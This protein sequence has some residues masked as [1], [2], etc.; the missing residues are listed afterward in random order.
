[1]SRTGRILLAVAAAWALSAAARASA[2]P[3]LRPAFSKRPTYGES[4]TF[5]ADLE[6]GGYVQ[7]SLGITNLLPGST[8]GVC[9]ALVV[10]PAGAI[11][12]ESDRFGRDRVSWSLDQE[13]RLSI[14]T[15]SA[16]IDDAATAVEARLGGGRVRLVFGARPVRRASRE[17]Q[18]A[19]GDDRYQAE[20]LLER[21]PVIATLALPHEPERTI[22]GGGYADH[23]RSTVP[24]REVA[25][26]WVRFRALRGERGLLLL[27]REGRDGRFAPVWTCS[28]DGCQ[29]FSAFRLDGDGSGASPAFRVSVE[30]DAAALSVRS[31]RLLYRDAPVEDL[32]VLGKIVAPFT[33]SPITY[34]Y[35]ATARDR[36][37]Q[38]LEGILEV[39]LND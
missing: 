15:C 12:K 33:G 39:E 23:S 21:S 20:V 24:P 14:G 34:V 28:E 22:A 35:R 30:N 19:V 5:I 16:W 11:W 10:Q 27:G 17:V 6:D 26:R 8:K 3:S 4:Y 7:V 31:G 37:G 1:V 29:L 38:A 13:E 9:R 36:A 18:V 2:T 32:G 25:R